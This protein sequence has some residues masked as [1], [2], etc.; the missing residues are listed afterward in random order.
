MP[1][2]VELLAVV[3]AK[4]WEKKEAKRKDASWFD[5]M[6]TVSLRLSPR[7]SVRASRHGWN[8]RWARL[9]AMCITIY[10]QQSYT[11]TQGIFVFPTRLAA[12]DQATSLFLHATNI[13]SVEM[14]EGDKRAKIKQKTNRKWNLKDVTSWLAPTFA[15]F[16][17]LLAIDI[18]NGPDRD[19][20]SNVDSFVRPSLSL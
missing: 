7:V 6:M 9:H 14:R 12:H 16:F 20:A 3:R 19:N 5:G 2:G 11:F 10:H 1:S 8:I 17:C 18:P 15:L 4:E 13:W